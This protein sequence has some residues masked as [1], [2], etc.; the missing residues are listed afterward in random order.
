[1]IRSADEFYSLV[2]AGFQG[3]IMVVAS[4]TGGD[5]GAKLR[6]LF[7]QVGEPKMLGC[8][9]L[10]AS[11]AEAR[12]HAATPPASPSHRLD[13]RLFER[14]SNGERAL[15]LFLSERAGRW[16][17]SSALAQEVYRRSDAAGRQLVWK[18][19]ST[20]RRKLAAAGQPLRVCRTRG[21]SCTRIELVS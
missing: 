15:L 12:V 8:V 3:P 9:L 7:N 2:Q 4:P 1:V 5:V 10:V 21:Y 18:Y 14:L 19:A 13:R 16:F 6:Q 20:L 17:S 11:E